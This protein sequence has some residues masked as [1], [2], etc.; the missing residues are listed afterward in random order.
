MR[1]RTEKP[2]CRN[3]NATGWDDPISEAHDGL[4]ESH[5][6]RGP[7]SGWRLFRLGKKEA[8]SL[9]TDAPPQYGHLTNVS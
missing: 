3:G 8:P 2:C 1:L 6:K 9:K 7:A 5:E 4:S